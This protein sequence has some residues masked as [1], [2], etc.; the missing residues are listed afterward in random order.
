MSSLLLPTPFGLPSFMPFCFFTRSA[1]RVRLEIKS[2]SISDA[3]EKAMAIILLWILLLICQSPLKS[4]TLIDFGNAVYY[5]HNQEIIQATKEEQEKAEACKRLIQ[6]AIICWNYFYHS[7]KILDEQNPQ[8]R[9]AL[10]VPVKSGSPITWS[11][12]ILHG[13]FDFSENKL[14]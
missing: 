4:N 5:G 8:K 3:I 1:S 6:N 2:R 12:I 7:K 13:E 14:K 11:H 9:D 10:L